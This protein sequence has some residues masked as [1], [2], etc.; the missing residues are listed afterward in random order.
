MQNCCKQAPGQSWLGNLQV[1]MLKAKICIGFSLDGFN[2]FYNRDGRGIGLETGI[3][4]H[5]GHI[6]LSSQN[7]KVHFHWQFHKHLHV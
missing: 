2:S 6:N 3:I 7:N 5:I 4:L 1:T